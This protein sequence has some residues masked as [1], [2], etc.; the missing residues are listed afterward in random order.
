MT[1]PRSPLLA[2]AWALFEQGQYEEA[3]QMAQALLGGLQGEDRRDAQRLM[4][5]ARYHQRQY[6]RAS[7]WLREACKGS[8]QAQDWLHLALAATM[9]GDHDLGEQA[10]EQARFCQQAAKYEQEPGW[11]VQLYW[12]AGVLCDSGQHER[13]LPLLEELASAYKRLHHTDTVFLY[14]RGLPF[15][16]SF[17]DLAVRCFRAL[18][19]RAEGIAWLEELARALDAAGQRQVGKAVGELRREEGGGRSEE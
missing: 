1:V 12:Y 4:G 9:Q 19:R 14:G 7:F 16:S 5:L 18:E 8:E 10:F 13:A 15:L 2:Q 11:Y 3:F 17:L 6:E